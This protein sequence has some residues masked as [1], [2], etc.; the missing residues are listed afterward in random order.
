MGIASKAWVVLVAALVAERAAGAADAPVVYTRNQRRD[1]LAVVHQQRTK[2]KPTGQVQ[3]PDL[4]FAARRQLTDLRGT[5]QEVPVG[6][7]DQIRFARVFLSAD[8]AGLD[9]IRFRTPPT[10]ENFHPRL[11]FVCDGNADSRTVRSWN[12]LPTSGE[13][14]TIGPDSTQRENLEIP[15]VGLPRDNFAI[16]RTLTGPLAP[17]TEYLVWF[18]LKHGDATPVFAKLRIDP[19]SPVGLSK[20]APL[21]KARAAFEAARQAL[22]KKYD[23]DRQALRQMYTAELIKA[24]QS[25]TTPPEPAERPRIAAELDEIGRD[26][27]TAGSHRGFKVIRAGYGVDDRWVD[28]TRQIRALVRGDTVRFDADPRRFMPDPAVGTRKTLIILYTLD[29]NLGTSITREGEQVELPPIPL[30]TDRIPPAP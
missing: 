12:I 14:P 17:A 27:A 3:G 18:D 29:G 8:G 23:A 11:E 24:P 7:G 22:D 5:F 26:E 10:G 30:T 20:T 19:V 25:P 2:L 9:A 1:L 6:R 15:G 28:V 21:P 4:D 16:S 13:G